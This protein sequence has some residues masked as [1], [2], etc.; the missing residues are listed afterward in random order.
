MSYWVTFSWNP[1]VRWGE[2]TRRQYVTRGFCHC[3]SLKKGGTKV[4]TLAVNSRRRVFLTLDWLA[5]KRHPWRRC[6]RVFLWAFGF[7]VSHNPVNSH[8]HEDSVQL[9]MPC[10]C[11]SC[12][13]EKNKSCAS[14]VDYSVDPISKSINTYPLTAVVS[15]DLVKDT[16]T[17]SKFSV[18]NH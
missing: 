18:E 2:I 14:K 17:S 16:D 12:I 3:L 10:S 5:G 7:P 13:E 4:E 9:L 11:I 15:F 6:R 1:V 8:V